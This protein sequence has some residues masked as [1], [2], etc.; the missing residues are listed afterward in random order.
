ME[1]GLLEEEK[2][3]GGG[4]KTLEE[5]EEEEDEEKDDEEDEYDDEYDDEEMWLGFIERNYAQHHRHQRA[6]KIRKDEFDSK[7]EFFLWTEEKLLPLPREITLDILS[8]LPLDSI[9]DCRLVCRTWRYLIILTSFADL[10][11]RRR[12]H[13]GGL[14]LPPSPQHE[15]HYPSNADVGKVGF[16]FLT[17]EKY[18]HL[19]YGE[20]SEDENGGNRSYMTIDKINLS[21][22]KK[23]PNTVAIVGSC[24]GLICSSIPCPFRID[25]PI[26]IFNPITREFLY[27]PRFDIPYKYR[28]TIVNKRSYTDFYMV[29]GFGYHPSTDLYKIVRIFYC[30]EQQPTVGQVQVYTLGSYCGWRNKGEI[31][32]S[33]FRRSNGPSRGVLAEGALHW[34]DYKEW[35][36]IAFDLAEEEFSLLPS[37]PCFSPS[38]SN[39]F[40]LQ[41]LGGCL[42]VAHEN[43]GESFDIWSFKKKTGEWESMFKITFRKGKPI[44]V[45][46]PIVL[47]MSGELLLRYNSKHLVRYNPRTATL[48]KIADLTTGLASESFSLLLVEA[49]P[50]I[51]S[52]VS[53]KALEAKSKKR[54]RSEDDSD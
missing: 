40:Q 25:D 29:S 50:H 15:Y 10:H 52:F 6:V 26:H 22:F 16:L 54:R 12:R 34:L 48:K 53:L 11:L 13:C 39:N 2:L 43:V 1:G 32:Y 7:M 28:K 9:L 14:L 45:H 3:I 30:G 42:C 21:P 49:I 47:T 23:R 18:S 35:D 38:G 33:L 44:D 8:R 17:M 46:W 51:H 36:I 20:Y 27:L 24:N 5:E 37:P 4:E 31:T 19:Y 41:V